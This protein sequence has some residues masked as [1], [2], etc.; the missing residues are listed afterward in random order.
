MRAGIQPLGAVGANTT[1]G[2]YFARLLPIVESTQTNVIRDELR[3]PD[4]LENI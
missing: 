2:F 1:N 3:S 4:P